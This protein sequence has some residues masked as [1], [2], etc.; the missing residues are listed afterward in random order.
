MRNLNFLKRCTRA[1]ILLCMVG[2]AL[3]ALAQTRVTGIVTDSQGNPL[4]GVGVSVPGTASGAVTDAEGKYTLTVPD[5]G[6]M[7]FGYLG[8][9][10]QTVTPGNRTTLD[11]TMTESAVQVDEVVVVGYGTMRRVDVTGTVASLSAKDITSSSKTNLQSALQGQVPGMIIS[12]TNNKPGGGFSMQMRGQGGVSAQAP[13]VIVDGV[14]DVPLE[15]LDPE[16]I[17]RIDV[18]KDAS[19]IAVYGAR[20]AGGVIMVTTKRGSEGRPVINY[21]GY[22]GFKSAINVPDF[23]QGDDYVQIAREYYR[24]QDMIASK[25]ENTAYR[26]DERIFT[27]PSE[28]KAVQDHNYYDWIKAISNTPLQTSHNLSATGGTENVKYAVGVGFYE[29]EDMVAHAKFDRY[30]F[31]ASVEANANKWLA[32]GANARVSYV[33]NN[34][35]NNDIL[36]DAFRARPTQHPSSLVDGAEAWKFSSNG[37]FN[38]FVTARNVTL[39]TRMTNVFGSFFLNITPVKGLSLRSS[40]SPNLR[41]SIQG[42]YRDRWSKANQGTQ[43]STAYKDQSN[44]V[45]W[46]W[47]NIANYK[48]TFNDVHSLDATGV[49]SMWKQVNDN[50][51][52]NVNQLPYNSLWHNLGS[53]NVTG[54]SSGYS[55]LSMMSY[56]GR[57]NYGFRE[58]YLLTLSGRYDGASQL[59]TGH[60][61][62]F[63][64]S[65]AAAWRIS[66]EPFMENADWVSNLKLRLSYGEAG[67]TSGAGA[68]GS[69]AGL[70]QTQYTFGGSNAVGYRPGRLNNPEIT[71]KRT[72]EWNL[73]LDFAIVG[74]G[75]VSGSVDVY[76][77]LTVGDI[78]SRTL[79]AHS[80]FGSITDN[81]AEVMNRGVEFMLH[82]VNV[83][84]RDFQWS[85]TFNLAYNR[86][87]LW[88]IDV[89]EDLGAFSPQLKGKQG[90]FAN[91]WV[92]GQP[93]NNNSNGNSY[94]WTYIFDGIWQESEREEAA[95]WGQQP[96][97][98]RM[99]DLNDDGKIDAND[100][101][102][103]GQS[104]P[105][106]NGG[107]VN[108]FTYKNWDLGVQVFFIAGGTSRNQFMVG[109]MGEG[110]QSNF[111]NIA[112]NY[113]TPENPS[114][115]WHQPGNQGPRR[116]NSSRFYQRTDYLKVGYITLGYT[117][118]KVFL[119][120]ISV[121]NAR[122]YA[123]VQNPFVITDVIATDPEVINT[124]ELGNTA[125]MT[126]TYLFG[127]NITF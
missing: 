82:T 116:N 64:P 80:G 78:M 58:R 118:P 45:E 38:P 75:R 124:G 22:V 103:Y 13:L 81:A 95:K 123:T 102:F 48:T 11:V 126:A 23:T 36:Q 46:T 111:K 51:R 56:V 127:L 93:L 76:R 44:R 89:K 121:S 49:F 74:G 62:A 71:W 91:K 39:Q 87:E 29:E 72:S 61:W 90:N 27:D 104:L 65:A 24:A 77:R 66:E 68:Y 55:Q 99:K 18:L 42:Q 83:K 17:E 7:V 85:T 119:D 21:S 52:G 16:S 59:A 73:G 14:M 19:S 1:L 6:S 53:G 25:G 101:D 112:H 96:G 84:T 2:F 41:N 31:N 125:L 117:V 105:P 113:W 97:Q 43:P 120:K 115:E 100:Q 33:D 110:T 37:I 70:A 50:M 10:D 108:E 106:W 8:Y 30:N 35:G 34:M 94:N 4:L 69:L 92:I 5:G 15:S 88:D 67:T 107:M 12:R 109:Y 26:T 114:N 47:D 9:L 60:K 122:L 79:P 86:N 40:F 3:P 54:L 32:F 57:V 98:L 20:G 28:L 63:F